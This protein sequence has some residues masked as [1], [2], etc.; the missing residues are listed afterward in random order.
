MSH[1]RPACC[2]SCWA[3]CDTIG[4][5]ASA[6]HLC[7]TGILIY[8]GIER[9]NDTLTWKRGGWHINTHE[10]PNGDKPHGNALTCYITR[11]WQLRPRL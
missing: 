8:D 9:L 3:Q 1:P 4:Y 10:F 5:T 6:V 11:A 7:C 2:L